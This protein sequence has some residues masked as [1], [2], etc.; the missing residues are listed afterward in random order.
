MSDKFKVL[1][2]FN[3][4]LSGINELAV[5]SIKGLEELDGLTQDIIDDYCIRLSNQINEELSER[6]AELISGLS[7]AYTASLGVLQEAIDLGILEKKDDGTFEIVSIAGIPTNPDDMLKEI[8]NRIPTI[9]KICNKVINFMAG[10]YKVVAE[11]ITELTPKIA[12][13]TINIE[14]LLN[15]KNNIPPIGNYNIDKLNIYVEPISVD[16]ITGGVTTDSL[17]NKPNGSQ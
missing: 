12:T 13:L 8:A 6:R 3:K 5:S 2:D 1:D 4:I 9:I 16:D 10:P 14:E 17:F 15:I 7:K 11:F